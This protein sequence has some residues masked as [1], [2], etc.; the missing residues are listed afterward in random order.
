M[1]KTLFAMAVLSLL[2]AMPSWAAKDMTGMWG[3]G[4]FR[5]EFPVGAR[6]W[7]TPKIAGDIGFGF[8]MESTDAPGNILGKGS[9]TY[10]FELGLPFVLHSTDNALFFIRPGLAYASA[11]NPFTVTSGTPPVTKDYFDNRESQM[12]VSGSLGAEYFFTERFSIEA[13]HGIVFK[14][15]NPGS[16]AKDV[17]DAK[18]YSAIET[19]AFGISNIGFHY[20]FGGK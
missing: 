18:T 3:P 17:L 16:D 9:T 8:S 7:F 12:W 10:G 1:K 15:F 11:P 20:Y 19:E 4:Y 6:I 2:A 5:S 14:S 13:A